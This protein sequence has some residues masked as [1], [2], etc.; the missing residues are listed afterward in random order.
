MKGGRRQNYNYNYE[1][2]SPTAISLRELLEQQKKHTL[3]DKRLEKMTWG[4]G[5]E[6]E[7]QY[8]YTPLTF[9]SVYKLDEIVVIATQLPAQELLEYGY[10]IRESDKDLLEKID[11]EQTG[12]ICGGKVV[13]PVLEFKYNNE[14]E[15]LRMPEFITDQPFSTL[16]NKKTIK[17]YVNQIIEKEAEFKRLLIRMKLMDNF[18][19]KN[20]L[21][22]NQYPFGMCSNIRVRKEYTDESTA[23]EK[24]VYQDYTGSYHFT[25]TLPFEK[26]ENYTDKDEKE[27]VERHY[28]FGAMFQWIEPLLLAAYFSCDQKAVGN[29]EKRIR[30]SF[31]V[32]RVGWGNFAGSDMRKKD[33]DVGTGRYATVEPYWRENFNFYESDL[34]DSCKV[35]HKQEKKSIS[36]FSSNI[37]TFGPDPSKPDDPKARISG[38]KMTIPNGMEIRIFDHFQPDNLLSLLQIIILVA[39]NSYT[40]KVKDFVYE[41][42]DWKKNLQNIM[43]QGWKAEIT[44]LF[45]K[46]LENVLDIK[47]DPKTMRAYDVLCDVVLRL[48]EKNKSSDVVYLMYGDLAMPI[49]PQINKFSWEFA[50][51]L[52][53]VREEKV[54][55]DYLK[56]IEDIIE[57]KDVKDF[58]KSVVKCFGKSWESNWLDMLYFMKDKEL[59]NLIKNEEEYEINPKNLRVFVSKAAFMNEIII[60]LNIID[61][62]FRDKSINNSKSLKIKDYYTCK[63]IQKRFK[64]FLDVERYEKNYGLN[65]TNLIK[66]F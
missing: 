61:V 51:M 47:T 32:A 27:F 60:Q 46:K 28:N 29:K 10:N 64:N 38:A 40:V 2:E 16:K 35:P 65:F 5:I 49:I 62:F 36:S 37:R 25:I 7:T 63:S 20:L 66:I 31:R 1:N 58:K 50:F 30:G 22:F 44:P 21:N 23:L 56:F 9:D 4:M 45:L 42:A 8:F 41:D 43:L 59:I 6:H 39:A 52:K 3:Q 19:Q 18:L 13:L 34:T 57:K 12:R 24:Q 14:I 15:P 26:K 55:N 11:F 33:A 53:V 54:Y 48:F 17:N